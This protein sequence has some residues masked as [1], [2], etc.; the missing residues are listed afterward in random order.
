MSNLVF[1]FMQCSHLVSHDSDVGGLIH[2]IM[3]REVLTYLAWK[4]SGL[5]LHKPSVLGTTG[6]GR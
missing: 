5:T 2:L 3:E 1:V 6:A 4:V